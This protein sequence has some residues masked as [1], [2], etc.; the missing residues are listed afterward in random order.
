LLQPG[1]LPQQHRGGR[2]LEDEGEGAVL[3]DRDL[4]RDDAAGLVLGGRVVLLAE[5]HRL[6]AVRTQR[7]A[8]RRGRGGLARGQLDLHDGG[9]APLRHTTS[10]SIRSG[11]AAM[12]GRYGW[13]TTLAADPAG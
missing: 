7:G 10:L 1:R 4:D 6:H 11:R 13:D 12:N 2:C 9:D 5:L 3:E 8:D